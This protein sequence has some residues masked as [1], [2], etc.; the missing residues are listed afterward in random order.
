MQLFQSKMPVF[1]IL[2]MRQSK[3]FLVHLQTL[4]NPTD[5]TFKSDT[6]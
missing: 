5:F 2:G 1:D 6:L 4:T 3:I